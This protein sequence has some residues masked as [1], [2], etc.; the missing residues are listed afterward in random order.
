[1]LWLWINCSSW[2]LLQSSIKP[3]SPAIVQSV[4]DVIR[5]FVYFANLSELMADWVI[6]HF[7][8]MIL[9]MI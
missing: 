3:F 7:K 2:I 1:M 4:L 8:K 6:A 5:E 9:L